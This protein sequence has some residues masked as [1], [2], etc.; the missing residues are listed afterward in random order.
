MWAQWAGCVH[1][2]PKGW[3]KNLRNKAEHRK[4]EMPPCPAQ[5]SPETGREGLGRTVCPPAPPTA[6]SHN[7]RPRTALDAC[8]TT[9]IEYSNYSVQI[10]NTV[11]SYKCVISKAEHSP[12]PVTVWTRH[13]QRPGT[14]VTLENPTRPLT[15]GC[16][17]PR[18]FK[19]RRTWG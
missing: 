13:L 7:E 14:V 5:G 12:G 10:E 11:F 19:T 18:A 17:E 4:T 15:T 2:P 9:L 1:P 3:L 6:I 8:F 16:S